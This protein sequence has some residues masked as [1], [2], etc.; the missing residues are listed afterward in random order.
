MA[1]IY[2][3]SRPAL[4]LLYKIRHHRGHGIHSP[5]LFSLIT[6][7][8]EEKLP[9]YAYEDISIFLA[10]YPLKKRYG[11]KPARLFFRMVNYF[12]ARNILEIGTG[13]GINTLYLTASSNAIECNAVEPKHEAYRVANSMCKKWGRNVQI[14]SELPILRKKQDCILIDLK[15]YPNSSDMLFRY[16]LPL[17]HEKTFIILKS[18]RTNR[19]S[20]ALWRNLRAN[21]D[22]T[23]TLDLFNLGIVFFDKKL[24]R[25]NY[26]IS[27]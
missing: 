5:F 2:H 15:D 26:K 7:V 1:K 27:F 19:D 24:Y 18:I 11:A 14:H 10:E 4:R 22:V 13:Y 12:D 3:I 9:Y 16:I 25:Y 21:N 6:K 23:V 20:K 8:I 17:C